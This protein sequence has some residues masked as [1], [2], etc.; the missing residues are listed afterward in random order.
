[1][2]PKSWSAQTGNPS[3][4]HTRS[5]PPLRLGHT[6]PTGALSQGQKP[7]PLSHCFELTSLEPAGLPFLKALLRLR[8]EG[9]RSEDYRC[10][11]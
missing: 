9:L 6:A 8:Q 4:Q 10:S 3:T 5:G 1:M 7:T 11:P 2:E